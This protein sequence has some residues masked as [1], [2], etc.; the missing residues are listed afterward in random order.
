MLWLDSK[1]QIFAIMDVF[2]TINLGN[3]SGGNQPLRAN[4]GNFNLGHTMLIQGG[5]QER[6]ER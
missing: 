3:I 2:K 4:Y 6:W 5:T 1:Y